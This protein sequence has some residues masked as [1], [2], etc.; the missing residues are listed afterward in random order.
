MLQRDLCGLGVTCPPLMRT[1]RVRTLVGAR[2]FFG[3]HVPRVHLNFFLILLCTLK[4]PYQSKLKWLVGQNSSW[5]LVNGHILEMRFGA[6]SPNT[7]WFSDLLHMLYS[8]EKPE[9]W[10]SRGGECS[11]GQ[12]ALPLLKK[13]KPNCPGEIACYFRSSAKDEKGHSF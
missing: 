12:W 2:M 1:T 10:T 7:W 4:I 8:E 9:E 3:A 11:P 13:K 6:N 5:N